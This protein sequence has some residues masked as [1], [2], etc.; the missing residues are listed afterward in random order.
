MGRRVHRLPAGRHAA[1]AWRACAGR[2]VRCRDRRAHSR[3]AAAGPGAIRRHRFRAPRASPTRN[4]RR[5]TIISPRRSPPLTSRRCPSSRPA[6]PPRSPWRSS[7]TSSS[8]RLRCRRWRG[9]WH[10]AAA[11]S[12]SS[13]TTRT[14]SWYSEPASRTRGLRAGDALLRRR[15]NPHAASRAIRA[16]T[17]PAGSSGDHGFDP[18]AVH[19]FPVL[20]S[21]I[22]APVARVWVERRRAIEEEVAAATISRSARLGR[23]LVDAP[24]PLC[25]R[26]TPIWPAPRSSRSN[27]PCSTRPSP[28]AHDDPQARAA[29]SKLGPGRTK[30]PT[31]PPP[32]RPVPKSPAPLLAQPPSRPVCPVAQRRLA[33]LGR[34]CSLLRLGERPHRRPSRRGLLASRRVTHRGPHARAR[35]R[36]GTRPPAARQGGHRHRRDRPLAADARPRA[37]ASAPAAH[38]GSCRAGSRRH[39]RRAGQAGRLRPRDRAVRHPPVAGPRGRPHP[40]AAGRRAFPQ[41]RWAVRDRSGAR[42]AELAGIRP[43]G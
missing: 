39:S 36:H 18:L 27:T 40:D 4:A 30:P 8:R 29:R 42:R 10:T 1:P 26:A 34:L 31:R 16:R 12:W 11:S 5:A 7:S 3:P 37:P 14:A 19:L 41:T 43:A 17:A 23:D 24:W 28:N 21:R 20:V 33:W 15:S 38:A 22:G 35:L 25:S 2:R 32:S 9:S 6:S 13:P